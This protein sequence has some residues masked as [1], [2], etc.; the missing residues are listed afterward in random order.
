MTKV[1]FSKKEISYIDENGVQKE[2]NV[3]DSICSKI[4]SSEITELVKNIHPDD[5]MTFI[6]SAN[7]I[8]KSGDTVVDCLPK[9]ISRQLNLEYDEDK[10]YS[11]MD[12]AEF[13]K[14]TLKD[15][16]KKRMLIFID[17]IL[18]LLDN[19]DKVRK[20]EG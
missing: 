15:S 13:L 18:D 17:E 14:A 1:I 16:G 7:H 19:A 3:V 9:E 4:R 10:T 8:A 11:A 6:F 12:V 2:L 20:F 5:Y